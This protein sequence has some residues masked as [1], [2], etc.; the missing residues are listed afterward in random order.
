[1]R[2]KSIRD[3]RARQPP[4]HFHRNPLGSAHQPGDRS[5]S[6]GGPLDCQRRARSSP[7]RRVG[8]FSAAHSTRTAKAASDSGLIGRDELRLVLGP[9][10]LVLELESRLVLRSSAFLPSSIVNSQS[11]GGVT[12]LSGRSDSSTS[13]STRTIIGNGQSR[14]KGAYASRV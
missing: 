14:C 6:A 8:N 1:M 2:A 9:G 10:L 4:A 12:G 7:R 13:T 11:G 5:S 3:R